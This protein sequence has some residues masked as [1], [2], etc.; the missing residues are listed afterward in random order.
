MVLASSKGNADEGRRLGPA[1][2]VHE[3]PEVQDLLRYH[4]LERQVRTSGQILRALVEIG[5]M[6]A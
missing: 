2:L 5:N 3:R 6:L 4:C 1:H